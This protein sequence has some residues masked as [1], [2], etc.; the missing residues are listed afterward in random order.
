MST[1]WSAIPHYGQNRCSD[2]TLSS[3]T[4]LLS[5]L[6]HLLVPFTSLW[7]GFLYRILLY[8]Y[9]LAYLY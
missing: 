3:P 4:D 5:Y 2:L 9:L 6:V 8:R 7:L 1:E